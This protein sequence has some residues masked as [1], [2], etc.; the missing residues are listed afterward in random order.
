MTEV[1]HLPLAVIQSLHVL[2]ELEKI[3]RG[4]VQY[5]CNVALPCGLSSAARSIPASSECLVCWCKY[6][7][8]PWAFQSWNQ[9][10]H[11]P[12]LVVGLPCNIPFNVLLDCCEYQYWKLAIA[13]QRGRAEGRS[14]GGSQDLVNY[15][16]DSI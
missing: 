3:Q 4:T 9:V 6:C 7:K 13:L 12:K 8:W 10:L 15:V 14:S 1:V 5:V 11:L 16:N 2:T